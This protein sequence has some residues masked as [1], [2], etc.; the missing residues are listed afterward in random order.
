MTTTTIRSAS[1]HRTDEALPNRRGTR[2]LGAVVAIA[3]AAVPAILGLVLGRSPFLA[4][5]VPAAAIVG[6]LL[7]PS[8]RAREPIAALA[9]AMASITIAV[10]DVVVV[11]WLLIEA[12]LTPPGTSLGSATFG[13]GYVGVLG[14][15]IVG[16]PMLVVTTPCAIVWG[17]AV[18]RLVENG[19]GIAVR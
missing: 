10:A 9:F 11:L 4:A 6:A 19:H 7:G 12:S 16:I 5:G 8:V 14:L 1:L 13:I 15:F 2:S 17:H 3:I 18:R